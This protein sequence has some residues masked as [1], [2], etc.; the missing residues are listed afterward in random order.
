MP[1][2]SIFNCGF[3]QCLMPC[4]IT[5][6]VTLFILA[7][8]NVIIY[9]KLVAMAKKRFGIEGFSIKHNDRIRKKCVYN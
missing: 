1:I 3:R 2:D 6:S 8:I 7:I 9:F 4:L 5:F